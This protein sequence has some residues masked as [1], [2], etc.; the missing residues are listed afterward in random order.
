VAGGEREAMTIDGDDPRNDGIRCRV[1]RPW[2]TG[3]L[4]RGQMVRPA[5]VGAV[6][7]LLSLSAGVQT[8]GIAIFSFADT[9]CGAWGKSA[10]NEAARAQYSIGFGASSPATTQATRTIK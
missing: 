6:A 1:K 8:P 7:V 9:S 5:I 4:R 10:T 2:T 3:R